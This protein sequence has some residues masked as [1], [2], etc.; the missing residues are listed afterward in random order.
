MATTINEQERFPEQQNALNLFFARA[1]TVN[2]EVVAYS[3]IFILALFTRFY[4]LGDRTMSHDESL[5]TKF[6]FDLYERGVFRHTPLMHGPILFHFTALSYWLF[7]ATDFSARIYPALLGVGVVM[8]PLLFRRW[9]G[10]SG[11]F[12]A[13]LM[14]LISPI[15]LYYSRYIRHDIPSIFSALVMLYAIMMYISGPENQRRR[16]HWLYILA[17]AMIW[18]LGSK[19]TSFIYIAIF[20]AF[21]TLYWLFRLAQD[22]Y[23]LRGKVL[24]ETFII[25]GLLASVMALAMIVVIS[26][27]LGNQILP[28]IGKSGVDSVTLGDRLKFVG[29]QFGYLISGQAVSNE[30]LTFLSW[31]GLVIVAM[32]SIVLFPAI[33]V[34]RRAEET[35]N[36]MDGAM[37][38]FASVSL[39]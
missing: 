28:L 24:F 25:G 12:L 30:F 37:T 13:A 11:A 35:F 23:N 38:V 4:L 18:N 27:T 2:W 22:F 14:L 26:I 1:I 29:D 17:A 36:L 7:G 9:L 10:R 3:V 5:H 31:T 15:M 39:C 6:S 20:G 8:F 19:E 32:L 21:I 33:W 34:Y 16:A